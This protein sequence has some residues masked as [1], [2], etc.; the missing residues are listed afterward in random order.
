MC[1]HAAIFVMLVAP[2]RAARNVIVPPAAADT[3]PVLATAAFRST[4]PPAPVVIMPL[5]VTAL[6]TCNSPPTPSSRPMLTMLF[7]PV[8]TV[9]TPPVA[10][11]VPLASFFS[12]I[13]PLP[14]RP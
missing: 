11:I 10:S 6:C 7:L 8:S 13:S 9:R 2:L 12:V 5:L 1:W 4:L 14:S 3:T